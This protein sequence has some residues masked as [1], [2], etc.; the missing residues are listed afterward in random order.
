[1]VLA[2]EFGRY[3]KFA[4][5]LI[6]LV[7][8]TKIPGGG[9]DWP[10]RKHDGLKLIAE[11]LKNNTNLGFRLSD[12]FLVVD[13]D[14]RKGGDLSFTR[15]CK[16]L[17]LDPYTWPRVNTGRGDGGTHSYLK[18]PPGAPKIMQTLEAFPG[19]EFKTGRGQQVVCAGSL[20]PDS[21]LP[22]R[23]DDFFPDLADVP[24]IPDALLQAIA[25]PVVDFKS[26]G[27]GVLTSEQVGDLLKHVDAKNYG[28]GKRD[29]WL[30]IGMAV[31]HAT[32]GDAREQWVEWSCSDPD[33]SDNEEDA[34]RVW[35][36]FHVDRPGSITVA[37]LYKALKDAG[38]AD[39]IPKPTANED[40]DEYTE[41]E[42]ATPEKRAERF[43]RFKVSELLALPSPKWLV[44]SIMIEGGL[45]EIY[46]KYKSGKTFWAVEIACCVATGHDLFDVPVKLGKVV[47]IIAEGSRKLFAYRMDAW[48]KVRAKDEDDL[49]RLRDLVEANIEVVPVV[50]HINKPDQ[51][52][53]FLAVDV[54]P[55]SLVVI[56][57]LF[58][59]FAGN[60]ADQEAFSNF[61]AGCDMICRVLKCAVLFLHHQKRNDAQG[62]FGSVVAEASVD[63]A[64]MVSSPKKLETFLSLEIMRDGESDIPP[65]G[66]TIKVEPIEGLSAEEVATVGTLQFMER[67]ESNA[68][69]GDILQLIYN[70]KPASNAV[71][72]AKTG[73]SKS[74]VI[75]RLKDLRAAGLVEPRKL[76]LTEKGLGRVAIDPEDDFQSD[77]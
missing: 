17:K 16:H 38:R 7:G 27:G 70:D 65:W 59:N 31:H 68:R 24:T 71:I 73:L 54:S 1:M 39:L 69:P 10:L 25:R 60:V 62:G 26:S 77:D 76:Q 13:A 63:A 6:P 8:R 19:L 55:C 58:R 35:D 22:Y 44:K 5:N 30:H 46:G 14:P 49:K 72:E 41:E 43:K 67:E 56:D 42:G 47:Y 45:F 21:G 48:C 50:V 75:R 15:L 4:G 2:A 66:A 64:L 33:F 74:T 61:V 53:A 18:L 51:V 34:G 29:N 32:G 20:H 57:T 28:K 40:F 36:S 37:T 23:W 3:R 52:K 12:D 11:A 9:K